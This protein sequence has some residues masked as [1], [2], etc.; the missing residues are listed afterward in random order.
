VTGIS[1]PSFVL[2][3]FL[4]Y[5]FATQLKILPSGG[6]DGFTTMILPALSLGMI[7]LASLARLMR[8]SMLEVVQ[9]DYIRTAKAKGLRL[10]QIILKHQ[11]RN[12]ILP[13]I[14]YIG[15]LIATVLT[16]SFAIEKVFGIP[17][18]GQFFVNSVQELDYTVIMGLTVFYAGFAII[19][20]LIAD[21]LYGLVDPRIRMAK[22]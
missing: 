11:I 2:A 1:I 19:V 6:W 3:Y 9:Q 18:L 17:G 14:I 12:A 20:I 21:L 13:V 10:S 16:G 22:A 7:V 5:I 15:P 4:Q 8:N